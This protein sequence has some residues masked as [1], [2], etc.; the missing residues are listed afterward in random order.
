MQ[1]Q[2]SKDVGPE[3]FSRKR[4]EFSPAVKTLV[5]YAFTTLRLHRIYAR[6]MWTN[7]DSAKVLVNAGSLTKVPSETTCSNGETSWIS[8]STGP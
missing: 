3:Q 7:P 8:R 2:R 4:A 1:N 6:I 5:G